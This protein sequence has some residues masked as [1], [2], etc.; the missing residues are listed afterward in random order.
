[1]EQNGGTW[2]GTSTES[3]KEAAKDAVANYEAD[4]GVPP[5][6]EPVTLKVVE[7]YVTVEN[8]LH[9]YKVVLGPGG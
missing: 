1:M 9:D 4:R 5:P 8:P 3:F 6:G 7:M 2:P